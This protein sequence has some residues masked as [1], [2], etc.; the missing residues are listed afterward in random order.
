MRVCSLKG[1]L[2]EMRLITH[3]IMEIPIQGNS[4]IR[5]NRDMECMY[6][7]KMG[8]DMKVSGKM[9]REMGKVDILIKME[10]IMKDNG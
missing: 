5:K 4:W 2:V 9:I 6:Q 10:D 3:M 1:S 7:L 8:L